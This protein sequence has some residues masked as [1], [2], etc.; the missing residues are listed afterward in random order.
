MSREERHKVRAEVQREEPNSSID[1]DVALHK[2]KQNM[3]QSEGYGFD[4][5]MSYAL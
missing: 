4:E 5:T 2:P 3:R 1:I